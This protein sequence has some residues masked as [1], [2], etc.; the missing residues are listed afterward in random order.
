MSYDYKQLYQRNA[1]FLNKRSALKTVVV[2]FNTLVPYLF[3]G[4]YLCLWIYLFNGKFNGKD[5]AK[6]FFLPTLAL[7]LVSMIRMG[8]EKPRPYSSEGAGIV[9]LKEK[10]SKSSFPSRH[11]ACA[12][13]IAMSFFPFLPAVSAVLLILTMGLGYT[14]FALGWH[15]PSDL[16]VGFAIGFFI[17]CGTFLF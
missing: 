17:G 10:R 5:Y 11:L 12:A 9:P 13:V 2:W 14:R 3:M 1:D 16:L 6:V 4:A 7:L 15:Y 8:A